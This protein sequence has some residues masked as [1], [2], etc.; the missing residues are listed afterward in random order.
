MTL[1]FP[2]VFFSVLDYTY[3]NWR[4][5]S[6]KVKNSLDEILYEHIVESLINGDYGMGQNLTLDELA[7]RFEV[8]RTPVVQAVKL[9]ANDG[10]LQ[11]M[12][13]GRI[14]VPEYDQEHVRQMCEVRQMVEGHAL[15]RFMSGLGLSAESV[16][17]QLNRYSEEG[18]RLTGS[19]FSPKEFA[20]LD[21]RFHRLLVEA[22]GNRILLETYDRV[23]GR[24]LVSNYLLCPLRLRDF[25]GTARD[26][27]RLVESIRSGDITRAQ[28]CLQQHIE[29]VL[30]RL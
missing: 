30:R 16:L 7:H 27:V 21:R 6:M 11:I 17:A 5:N 25:S 1:L 23:Q 9:L 3:F 28:H 29:G 13:N 12:G 14:Y 2:I 24:F 26:H 10:I 18:V 8:S 4:K 15:E 20:M 19:S 22:S